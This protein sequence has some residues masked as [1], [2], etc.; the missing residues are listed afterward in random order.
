MIADDLSVAQRFYD[1]TERLGKKYVTSEELRQ[2]DKFFGKLSRDRI[3]K[4][5]IARP[6]IYSRRNNNEVIENCLTPEYFDMCRKRINNEA[7]HEFYLLYT[8]KNSGVSAQEL[9]DECPWYRE[10]YRDIVELAESLKKMPSVFE[11]YWD[12]ENR[13]YKFKPTERVKIGNT[14]RKKEKL[15]E[16]RIDKSKKLGTIKEILEKV[17]SVDS[18]T[19]CLAGEIIEG[20]KSGASSRKVVAVVK[21]ILRECVTSV[22]KLR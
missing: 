1:V 10:R 5:I 13:C 7:V 8:A 11:R 16:A 18:T 9:I 15:L 22:D 17:S 21:D 3:A 6:Q 20:V 12:A 14:L 4:Y 2:N 19:K